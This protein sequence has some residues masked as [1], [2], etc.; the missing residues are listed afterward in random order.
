MK[1]KPQIPQPSTTIEWNE[2]LAAWTVWRYEDVNAI[3]KDF[4][5]SANAT[6][7]TNSSEDILSTD[8]NHTAYRPHFSRTIQKK[9]AWVKLQMKKSAEKF[10]KPPKVGEE[11]DL[12]QKIVVPCCCDIV[13]TLMGIEVEEKEMDCLLQYANA[14]FL[15]NEKN[16]NKLEAEEATLALSQFFL[17]LMENRKRFPKDDLVSLLAQNGQANSLFLSPIIQM[18]VGFTTSL[19][20]LLGNVF[21]TL[22]A[23]PILTQKFVRQSN[24][25]LNE[26]LR[27]AGPAQFV[28]RLATVDAKVGQHIFKR[29]DRLALL[30]SHAN[31]DSSIFKTSDSLSLKENKGIH[32]SLGIGA[33]ACL[34][35]PLIRDASMILPHTFLKDLG[36]SEPSIVEV[37]FGGSQAICGVTTL[38][39]KI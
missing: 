37:N 28:Y 1:I 14:V 5:F 18:F 10:C 3:L 15:M 7:T 20:L 27:Y 32:L 9:S 25:W 19:P 26:I 23:Q 16:S 24:Q 22:L 30:L 38:K 21:L 2:N 29:G 12:Q 17:Q 11:F 33:H 6:S 31:R 36:K 4:R 35:S 34:G 8:F 39:V 13:K